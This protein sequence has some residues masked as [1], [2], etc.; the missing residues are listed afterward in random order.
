MFSAWRIAD[1]EGIMVTAHRL[2]YR[3]YVGP[4]TDPNIIH[5]CMNLDCT[6]PAH[7][8]TGTQKDVGEMN[9]KLGR[10]PMVKGIK[11]GPYLHKQLNRAYKYS[12]DEIQWMRTATIDEMV[13]EYDITRERASRLRHASRVGYK[14]LPFD[15][16]SVT[17]DPRGRKSKE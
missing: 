4:I 5:K 14:W 12:T 3:I 17:R 13:E 10:T 1:G 11:R 7:L 8:T 9:V 16:T 6:N 15:A 2:A